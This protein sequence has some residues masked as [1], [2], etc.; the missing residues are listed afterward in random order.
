MFV[1]YRDSGLTETIFGDY[2]CIKQTF[3]DITSCL[4][5]ICTITDS[6]TSLLANPILLSKTHLAFS[7]GRE[8]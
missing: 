5:V 2:L 6:D 7:F 1:Y 8:F 3:P 4:S